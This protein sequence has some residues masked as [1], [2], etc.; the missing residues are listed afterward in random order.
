MAEPTQIYG[1]TGKSESL[2]SEIYVNSVLI[3]GSDDSGIT[4]RVIETDSSGSIQGI[5]RFQDEDELSFTVSDDISGLLRL[6]VS[7]GC[8]VEQ[9]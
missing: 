1:T 8:K 2:L 6:R 4:K 7:A 5:V 3:Y 9:R